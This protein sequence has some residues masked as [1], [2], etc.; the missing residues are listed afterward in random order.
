MAD[1]ILR[2]ILFICF[3]DSDTWHM[4]Q[5]VGRRNVVACN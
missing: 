3:E 5:L 2:C 1:F 4:L